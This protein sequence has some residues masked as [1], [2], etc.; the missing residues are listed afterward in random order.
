MYKIVI[1]LLVVM[2][3]SMG[4]GAK[5]PSVFSADRSAETKPVVV[6]PGTFQE[7]YSGGGLVSVCCKK[8]KYHYLRVAGQ[9]VAVDD[10]LMSRWKK[11]NTTTQLSAPEKEPGQ[12]APGLYDSLRYFEDHTH[13][14]H[15][16]LFADLEAT[17]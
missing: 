9:I 15:Q 17:H 6:E 4:A 3:V 5:I 11:Q 8:G 16:H 13:G 12:L 2:G 1:A 14:L 10:V 7:W